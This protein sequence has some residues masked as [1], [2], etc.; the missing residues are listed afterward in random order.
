MLVVEVLSE[1]TRRVDLSEKKEAYLTI[2]SLALYL[3]C[4]TEESCVTV[5]R[6]SEEGFLK[7]TWRDLD[8]QI[9]LPEL[10]ISLALAEI[11]DAVDFSTPTRPE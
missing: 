8:S 2:P 1:S 5:W 9:T 7:E 4:E 11:Y 3:I 10:G 6:R